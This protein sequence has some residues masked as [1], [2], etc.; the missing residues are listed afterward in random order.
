MG[1]W[2]L[3][4]ISAGGLALLSAIYVAGRFSR[5][6]GLKRVCRNRREEKLAGVFLAAVLFLVSLLLLGTVNAVIVMLHL[7][8]IWLLCEGIA[9]V[10]RKI[11]RVS[12]KRYWTGVAA[13][14]LTAAYLGAGWYNAQHVAVTE[15]SVGNPAGEK[16]RIV[17]ISDAHVGA[18]FHAA[19]FLKHME[20]VNALGPDVVVITGDFTD[21]NTSEEDML[22]ACRALGTL[23]TKYGV[24]YVYGNHDK[25]RYEEAAGADRPFRA[26]EL[27][28]ALKEN[29]VVILE[30][31]SV[32]LTDGF[33]LIGRR[34]KSDRSRKTAAE[35][36]AA[37]PEGVYTVM[38]DH[39]PSDYDAEAAAGVSL[40]LSGHTHGGQMLPVNRAGEWLRLNDATYGHERRGN[41]DFIVNSGIGCWEL[42]FKTGCRSE[43]TV[44]DI[45]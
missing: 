40:V 3:I 20:T 22:A 45:G 16:L 24:Y 36:M 5:F 14:V 2:S 43:I 1:L 30:D 33:T 13:L 27:A 42:R 6:P 41:T 34:D 39:Q 44:I 25:L 15:Y 37:V 4:L 7:A 19:G 26:S 29:G 9:F 35:L 31:E 17:Q 38:L 8:L 32:S 21:G 12:A 11:G 23:R 18:T 10:I 28:E